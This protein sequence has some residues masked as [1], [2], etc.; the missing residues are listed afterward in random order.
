MVIEFLPKTSKKKF[1]TKNAFPGALAGKGVFNPHKYPFRKRGFVRL[2][3][4]YY[5]AWLG[6]A[7][8]AMN[9]P[10]TFLYNG[11]VDI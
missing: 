1:K 9:M 11:L 5:L 8:L 10:L 2:I 7:W 6:L 3:I 4:R